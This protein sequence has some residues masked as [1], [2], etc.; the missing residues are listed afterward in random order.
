MYLTDMQTHYTQQALTVAREQVEAGAQV[1]DINMDEGMLDS[2]NAMSKFL[3]LIASEPD[4]SRV[5]IVIDSSNFTVIETGL[6]VVQGKCIVNSIRYTYILSNQNSL[7]EGEADFIKKA[8]IVKRFGAAVIVMAVGFL[9]I[10][11]LMQF[12]ENGQATSI[13]KKVEICTRSY[14]ILTQQCGFNPE[15]IIFDPNILTIGTGIEEHNEY[16]I[17]FIE[18]TKIIKKVLP[19]CRVN[20]SVL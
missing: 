12:D 18:A 20:V 7:K 14:N 5:P 16:A 9:H 3:R 17:N 8:R 15:D 1:L 10:M 4:I 6:K 13:Q 19:Y 11:T 2:A